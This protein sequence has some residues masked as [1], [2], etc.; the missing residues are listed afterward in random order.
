MFSVILPTFNSANFLN[1][2]LDSLINQKYQK[3]E[4]IASDD[5][6]KDDTVKIL[7]SYSNLFK[8][9]KINFIIIKNTHLGAG[10]AR[11]QAI[12][13]S[14]YNWL[15]FLDSDDVWHIDKLFKMFKKIKKN[16]KNN[17]IIHNEIKVNLNYTKKYFNYTDMFSAK[18]KIFKQIFLKNFLSP[19]SLCI[20]KSLVEKYGMFDI[21]LFNAQDYDLWLKIGDELKIMKV[22]SYLTYY[23]ER[24]GSISSK[25]YLFRLRN[26]LKIISRYNKQVSTVDYYYKVFRLF[27]SKEWFKNLSDKIY[28]KKL[29]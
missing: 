6:S 26:I 24:K 1:K 25:P 13:K 9:K 28:F 22:N 29:Y 5:G 12:L 20:K 27:I 3:F 2:A 19:S 15:A 11:N 18:E 23:Y 7:N 21:T 4:V 10:N 17:C 8:K 14:K 16:K